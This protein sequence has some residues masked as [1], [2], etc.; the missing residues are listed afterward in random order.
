MAKK[1]KVVDIVRKRGADGEARRISE[2]AREMRRDEAP[3]ENHEGGTLRLESEIITTHRDSE[4]TEDAKGATAIE[5]E[6][7]QTI[8]TKVAEFEREELTRFGRGEP[9]RASRRFRVTKYILLSLLAALLAG[10]AY[11]VIA[12]LP[13]VT[14]A[15]T[16]KK[17]AWEYHDAITASQKAT[18]VDPQ[19]KMI[20]A[21]TFSQRKNY[22]FLS[23]AHGKKQVVRNATGQIVLYNAYSSAPQG[24][25]AGTRLA[26]P[27]GK[28]FRLA[29][30]VRVP[31]AK[32]VNGKIIA[33]AIEATVNADKPGADYNVGEVSRFTIPGFQGSSKY[34][35]FYAQSKGAI[36]GGIVGEVTYPTDADIANAKSAAEKSLADNLDGFLAAQ[37]PAAFKVIDGSR[38]FRV[39]KE[40]A[41]QDVDEKGNFGYFVDAQSSVIVFREQDALALM[42][43]FAKTGAGNTALE[44]KD[45][46]IQYA[47]VSPDFTQ[48]KMFL[49]ADFQGNFWQPVQINDFKEKARGKGDTDLRSLIYSLP[50]IERAT[51]S[52]WPFWVT[53]APGDKDKIA[54]DV[55]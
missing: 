26:T 24:L 4:I 34:E 53:S 31:G 27:D 54:V 33:S 16:T 9:L 48:G 30:S 51:I 25:V 20:P 23:T 52:F 17:T 11:A 41:Q 37:V 43:A 40:Q 19:N 5:E 45:F 8:E 21:E 29:R 15:I 10:G 14:I 36:S 6:V 2:E 42:S 49:R 38:Q 7:S 28:I 32:I 46:T 44:M 22:I 18:S 50:G 55:Q 12:V 35:K 13:R 39:F 47:A 3:R 1:V